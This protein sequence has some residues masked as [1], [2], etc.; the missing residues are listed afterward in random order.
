MSYIYI[1]I[2]NIS[3]LRVKKT[4]TVLF[5]ALFHNPTA[6]QYRAFHNVLW[7]YTNLL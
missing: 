6:P 5:R 7:D 2:Y 1:Y 4:N 3:S